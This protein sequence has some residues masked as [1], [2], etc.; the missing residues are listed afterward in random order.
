MQKRILLS[1]IPSLHQDF[2]K[3]L[4]A[5]ETVKHADADIDIKL[6]LNIHLLNDVAKNIIKENSIDCIK[7][8]DTFDAGKT[9]KIDF[10]YSK[11]KNYDFVI[12]AD[13]E[14]YIFLKTHLNELLPSLQEDTAYLTSGDTY[15]SQFGIINYVQKKYLKSNLICFLKFVSIM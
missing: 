2:S 12:V 5:I 9:H 6:I 3:D 13:L 8:E 11:E 10:E 4:S 1:V 14:Q 7:L 15:T